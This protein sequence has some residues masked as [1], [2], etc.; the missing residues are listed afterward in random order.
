MFEMKDLK[1][2]I[3]LA[4]V[5]ATVYVLFITILIGWR[6]DHTYFIIFVSAAL[7]AHR[8][9][10]KLVLVLSAFII[11]W[12]IYDS[13]RIYPNHH[14]NP[15]HV[16][17][18]YN[19]ELKWFGVWDDG[20]KI[21]LS[22]WFETRTTSLLTALA[23]ISYL[24]W[25]PGPMIYAIYLFNQK[26]HGQLVDFTYAF[27]VTNIIGFIIYYAY[28]AAPPWYY[29]HYGAATDFTIPGNPGI[30]KEFDSLVGLKIFGSIYSKNSNVFAAIPSM[31]AAYPV[32]GLLYAIH[33]RKRTFIVVFTVLTFGIW[34]AAVYSQH[35]YII[36]L[37]LG[38]VC[39]VG[40]YYAMKALEKW[41]YYQKLKSLID[42]ELG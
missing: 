39:A 28:P 42:T 41:R 25:I 27:L 29:I 33:H 37:L 16:F 22:E 24:L 34:F 3:K 1:K 36:D 12:I 2:R 40:A 11:F 31:H 30:L 8:W 7:L 35:H 23:G 26:N 5:F 18:P 15:V 6:D 38:L 19:L 10:Y 9:T 20:R 17:E 14:F 21:V 32:I 4:I 13:M